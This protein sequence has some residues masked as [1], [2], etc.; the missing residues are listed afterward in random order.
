MRK[1]T[2]GRLLLSL[3]TAF[4]MVAGAL[5]TALPILST[6]WNGEEAAIPTVEGEADSEMELEMSEAG[7]IPASA[8]SDAEID[9]IANLPEGSMGAPNVAV[10]MQEDPDLELDEESIEEEP[11]PIS[12]GLSTHGTRNP[13]TVDAG[14][15]YGS[16]IPFDPVYEGDPI[17]FDGQIEPTDEHDNYKFRW[18]VNNDGNFDGPGDS[19]TEYFGEDGE[20]SMTHTFYD[21]YKGMALVQAWDGSW[22]WK[23]DS[24]YAHREADHW[25]Y[26]YWYGYYTLT[27]GWDFEVTK[28]CQIDELGVYRYSYP[29]GYYNIRVWDDTPS[30][31]AQISYPAS[32]Y[33]AWRWSSI[34][35]VD[36][37]AG[38]E[39]VIS[40]YVYTF[41]GYIT[42]MES[43]GET[44]DGIVIPGQTRYR[45][46]NGFPNLE[47]GNTQYLPMID[48]HYTC[49][50]PYPNVLED[51]ADVLVWNRE[52]SV[53]S[54]TV[55]PTS[56]NEGEAG[57]EF[58]AQMVDLG[59]MDEW[60]FQWDFGD[61]TMS[62]W[63][64]IPSMEGGASVLW[65]HTYTNYMDPIY[66]PLR[67]LMGMFPDDP[68]G[69]I[70]RYEE[71]DWGPLGNGALPSLEYLL[72]FNVVIVGTTWGPLD[73]QGSGDLMADY[74][75]AGGNAITLWLSEGSELW[76][77]TGRWMS[78][79]YNI[80]IPTGRQFATRSLGTVYD[81]T[82]PIMD[83]EFGTI[84]TLQTTLRQAAGD[85]ETGATRLA[86]FTIED[87][88]LAGYRDAG[89]K[90]PGT[91]RIAGLNYFPY[92]SY[93]SGDVLELL[94]NTIV[95]ASGGIRPK[96]LQQPY[97]LP[98]ISHIYEDDHPE[99]VTPSDD[100]QPRVRVRD[101][102]HCNDRILGDPLFL[103]QDF[104]RWG[105]YGDNPPTGWTIEDYGVAPTVWDY[106][107]WH[108][109]YFSSGYPGGTGTYAARV[110]YF[111]LESQDEELITPSLDVSSYS[112]V[113]LS[114]RHY[115][116]DRTT[117]R[118]DYGYVDVRFDGGS[119]SNVQTYSQSDNY[120]TRT[121]TISVPSGSDTMQVRW[122]YVAY[123]EYYW[124]VDNVEVTSGSD[125]LLDEDFNGAWGTYGNNPPTDWTI[126]DNGGA[127]PVWNTN[128]WHRYN[129]YSGYPSGT[130]TNAAR[131]YYY[132]YE[133][134]D[135]WLI[136]PVLDLTSGAYSSANMQFV[137]YWYR[138]DYYGTNINEGEILYR[139]DGGAWNVLDTYTTTID[140]NMWYDLS[141]GVNHQLEMAFHMTFGSDFYTGY[142]YWF[143]DNFHF[144]AIP[145]LKHVY[146]M[147]PWVDAP[148]VTVS[149]VFPWI[150]IPTNP[151]IDVANE[152]TEIVFDGFEINDPAL[153]A[154][155]ESFWYKINFDDGYETD[156]VYKGVIAP[157]VLKVLLYHSL[158]DEGI[159]PLEDALEGVLPDNA[160]ID[161][162]DFLDLGVA[163]VSYL[164]EYDVVFTG[165][166]WAPFDGH[167]VGDSLA[168]YADLGGN[169]V[170]TVAS[171]H[172]N[173]GWWGIAGRWRADDY[174]TLD[175]GGIGMSST[176]S[177]IYDPTHPIIDGE[178]G[179]VTSFQTGIPIS[180]FSE[181]PGATLLADYPNYP[182]AAYY[183]EFNPMP[184]AGRTVGLN[185]FY[186]PGYYDGGALTLLANAIWWASGIVMPSGIIPTFE[187]TWGDNGVYNVDI[188]V[189]D[190]D[191]YW[192]WAPGDL[193]PTWVGPDG[194]DP[195]DWISHNIIPI[196]VLNTDPIISPRI[197]AYAELDLSLRISGTKNC[198]AY[199]TLYENGA[200]IGDTMVT[201]VPGS[202][203]I[204][205]IN[206]VDLHVTKDKEYEVFV[207]V[208]D[209]SGGNPTWIFDMVFP[210]GKFKEFKHTFNDEHG[211]TWTI[212]DSMLKGALLGHDIIF[213][214]SADDAGSD[215]LAFVW[216]WGDSTPHG[217]HL[218]ANV[219]QDTAVEGVSDEATV[220]FNQ[221]SERDPAF[222][223]DAN[224]IRSPEPISMHADDMISH[225]FDESQP[226]YY[227]VTLIVMDDDVEDDY[228][229]TQLHPM[230]GADMC[231][232][233]IDFR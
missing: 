140:G 217:I 95:W 135:E 52:P 219:D 34:T 71:W 33:N 162:W 94:A 132:P 220:I 89:N 36:I 133:L 147:T 193:E 48:F 199:M 16:G 213:E 70:T 62:P 181:T 222:D 125:T 168:D 167:G 187:H 197:K 60:E 117:A 174:Q 83:G 10:S 30:V 79:D 19:S 46:G 224:D 69:W 144:E 74:V 208:V 57:S 169:V 205:V 37:E 31:I 127:A 215:D 114:Y 204:G 100:F 98:P 183:D 134:G 129:F 7:D 6:E 200:V 177:E 176:V 153:R 50:Y 1:E 158:G 88:V 105:P 198:D 97:Q 21:D 108:R 227:Y 218:F 56:S 203:N 77:M 63:M 40:V 143:V 221:L 131:C 119:W 109:Y 161:V 24:G 8:M 99:H 121:H 85:V 106:N 26:W 211:W 104:N 9:T 175:P 214:A 128:D 18:D 195:N 51:T 66:D 120:G 110:Y 3:F 184:G 141:A 81:P 172:T 47:T 154:R 210:D 91:G 76:G 164:A 124:F 225:V 138:Y 58:S 145:E 96:V 171:F 223:K 136:S 41:Y 90:G 73:Q 35:P 122:R 160:I 103:D 55:T 92:P 13:D 5:S 38:R 216:G 207:E 27:W 115:Y 82:H 231:Y 202:P 12:E 186:Y 180:T 61:G 191:M 107:D 149:N 165:I 67:D 102:D 28:D 65:L 43:Q 80:L 32:T 68:N 11:N 170:E 86:D 53:F 201:R 229:S 17:D 157:P 173:P 29:Y 192:D 75:D 14:G 179:V 111:P 190:D 25:G 64:R 87:Y 196:E 212:T 194:E 185:V 232:V 139:L 146:G 118:T 44:P 188:Q 20:S 116:N 101:D 93:A 155:T 233:E 178:F 159:G 72:G 163:D 4:I 2:T 45:S 226:Y 151:F 166:N 137:T 84:S 39:Y 112:S 59:I 15:P 113:S 152:R 182:A 78:E 22:T 206:N 156:W 150:E 230:P 130:G 54:P 123:Y 228:P 142:G 23:T 126:I 209:G 42:A 148:I 49:T 189:I